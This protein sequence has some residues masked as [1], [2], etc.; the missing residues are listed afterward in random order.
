MTIQEKDFRP[1]AQARPE[2]VELANKLLSL[3]QAKD[4]EHFSFVR[5]G[6]IFRNQAFRECVLTGRLSGGKKKE[7]ATY[8]MPNG[9]V[10]KVAID[11]VEEQMNADNLT[12][13]VCPF[14]LYEQIDRP[15]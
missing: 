4:D 13:V 9:K 12:L 6:L 15:D 7:F 1:F 14:H 5:V 3:T 8:Q 2:L 10:Y 11:M